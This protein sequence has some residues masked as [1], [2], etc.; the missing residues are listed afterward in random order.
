MAGRMFQRKDQ[1]PIGG[2]VEEMCIA[3]DTEEIE[4]RAAETTTARQPFKAYLV[5]IQGSAQP[6]K[7][8]DPEDPPATVHGFL[9]NTNAAS[10]TS[11]TS[12]A[13]QMRPE[14]QFAAVGNAS[15]DA[16]RLPPPAP[17]ES[18]LPRAAV[19]LKGTVLT[20]RVSNTAA[21]RTEAGGNYHVDRRGAITTSTEPEQPHAEERQWSSLGKCSTP[22]TTVLCDYK[23]K[24]VVQNDPGGLGMGCR[25]ASP[26]AQGPPG[27]EPLSSDPQATGDTYMV[28]GPLTQYQAPSLRFGCGGSTAEEVNSP[29]SPNAKL[30]HYTCCDNNPPWA[31]RDGPSGEE[32]L[33]CTEMMPSEAEAA[34]PL[35]NSCEGHPH[36]LVVSYAALSR[37]TPRVRQRELNQADEPSALQD[38]GRRNGR[39]STREQLGSQGAYYSVTVSEG[40]SQEAAPDGRDTDPWVSGSGYRDGPPVPP[41]SYSLHELHDTYK[42]YDQSGGKHEKGT[43]RERPP[44]PLH[45][46]VRPTSLDSLPS[47][48]YVTSVTPAQQYGARFQKQEDVAHVGQ[49]PHHL[50]K[51]ADARHPHRDTSCHSL[52]ARRSP[53]GVMTKVIKGHSPSAMPSGSSTGVPASP[54]P[55]KQPAEPH[56]S[57]L[58]N[59]RHAKSFLGIAGYHRHDVPNY[60]DLSGLPCLSP[61]RRGEQQN[62]TPTPWRHKAVGFWPERKVQATRRQAAVAAR[63]QQWGYHWQNPRLT[64]KCSQARARPKA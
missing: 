58:H 50:S 33:L 28:R 14:S 15:R 17:S 42:P 30:G 8:P 6:A 64:G 61:S 48:D 12:E 52:L 18:P 13:V 63:Q 36:S 11:L 49:T 57:S 10:P 27:L 45:A 22:S 26:P 19:T 44:L 1:V 40:A 21:G 60:E 34:E 25:L 29:A 35:L 47:G 59:T 43:G 32:R 2:T 46:T 9:T 38:E 54:T 39:A 20:L 4:A 55:G 41:P 53:V 31:R 62:P 7:A 56:N 3:N 5:D 24:I 16:V 23:R 51:A 37:G